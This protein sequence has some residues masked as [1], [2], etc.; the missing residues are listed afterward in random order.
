MPVVLHP[1][2]PPSLRCL[3][4]SPPHSLYSPT[5]DAYDWGRVKVVMD[6]G[7]G[8][9]ELLSSVMSWAAADCKGLLLDVQMVVDR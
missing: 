6:V 2:P 8:R 3:C 4:C 5:K 1:S 9:G 7:G